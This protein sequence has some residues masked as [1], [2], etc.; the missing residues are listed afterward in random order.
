MGRELEI[1]QKDDLNWEKLAALRKA[2]LRSKVS[3]ARQPISYTLP[4]KLREN[5]RSKIQETG[6]KSFSA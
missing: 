3:Q 2:K 1:K 5:N 6:N 4:A